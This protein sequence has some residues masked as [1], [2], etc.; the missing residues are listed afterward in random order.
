MILVG[1]IIALITSFYLLARIS[2]V[3]FVNSLDKIA[4]KLN[5]SHEMA[6]ATLMAIG[7]SAPELFVAIISFVRVGNHE[8]IGVGTI[9]GSA[10]FNILVIIG[11]S[12]MVRSAKLVWQPVMRDLIFYLIAVILL[13]IVMY[14]GEVSAIE[15]FILVGTYG[16]Y[17]LAVVYGRK[18]FKFKDGDTMD[19]DEPEEELKGW[20]L[21]FKPLHIILENIFPSSKHYWLTFF[22]SIGSIAIL[23]W[24]LVES[25]IGLSH[26]L[27]I[28]EVIIALTV[29]AI[30]TSIPDMMSSV[31][32]A[33]QG[34][35]G[36]AVSNAIGSN[37]FDILI[38][39]GLPWFIIILF[40]NKQIDTSTNDLIESVILLIISVVFIFVVL[41]IG[42]WK[43]NRKTGMFLIA[44][45]V[46]YLVREIYFVYN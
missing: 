37:I 30:G 46:I 8:A 9:V 45:Y 13:F 24:V 21:I 40:T 23:C 15:G 25:A 14:S 10:L 20:R 31:I 29:L 22:F 5:L 7:S 3:Y 44:L 39:L 36:M 33:K 28:P 41:L 27:N 11:A 16:L 18:I 12:A 1:Y 34:R 4:E 42:K 35:G 6:G 26:I 2:D 32:V 43:I 17:L 19:E 38:G